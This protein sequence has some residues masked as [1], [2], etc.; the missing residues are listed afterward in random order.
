MKFKLLAIILGTLLTVQS[1]MA[2]PFNGNANFCH[3]FHH[4]ILR[5]RI[6]PQ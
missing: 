4:L 3:R 5:E 2:A 6:F 1:A